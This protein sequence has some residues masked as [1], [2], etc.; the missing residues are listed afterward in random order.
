MALSP[1]QIANAV[2][3]EAWI[4]VQ[5]NYEYNDEYYFTNEGYELDEVFFDKQKAENRARE[6]QADWSA[7]QNPE[8]WEEGIPENMFEVLPIKVNN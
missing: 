4:V 6:C 1:D 8:M 5:Q 2:Q 3:L 7:Q